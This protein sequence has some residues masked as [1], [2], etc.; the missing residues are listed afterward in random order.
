MAAHRGEQLQAAVSQIAL[1]PSTLAV[2]MRL[3]ELQRGE[4][5]RRIAD[6][7]TERN[8]DH[9]RDQEDQDEPKRDQHIDRAGGN[10]VLRQEKGNLRRH[11]S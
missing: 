1:L 7:I 11:G 4:R 5:E 9:P 2:P 6:D 3:L 10:S 8:E